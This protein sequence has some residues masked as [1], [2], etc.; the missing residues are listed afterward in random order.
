MRKIESNS[1]AHTDLIRR[2]ISVWTEKTENRKSREDVPFSMKKPWF[3]K[4]K[5]NTNQH[6]V[7]VYLKRMCHE[8]FKLCFLS[9]NKYNLA[10]KYFRISFVA[11]LQRYKWIMCWSSA[12]LHS[13]GFLVW[14]LY[15][16]KRD[17]IH[18]SGTLTC[19]DNAIKCQKT[20]HTTAEWRISAVF[21]IDSADDKEPRGLFH[22]TEGENL[23]TLPL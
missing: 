12:M 9:L 18:L 6:T 5:I 15:V 21:W 11:S 7:I 23:L 19:V 17:I 20:S 4:K 1:I 22:K 14:N 3:I 13:G 8:I 16:N 2:T 10:R